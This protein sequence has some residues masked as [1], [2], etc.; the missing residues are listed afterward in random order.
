MLDTKKI[1][2]GNFCKVYHNGDWLMDVK[3]ADLS[4][5]IDKEEVPRAGTRAKGY[6][7]TGFGGEGTMTS[8]MTSHRFID[9]ITQITDDVSSPYFTE[10]L[11]EVN[12]PEA[13]EAKT[14][15]S[16]TDVQFDNAP[17]LSFE[18]GSLTEREYQFTFSGY[19]RK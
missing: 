3:A 14:F 1:V 11:F 9:L 4:L 8:Y 15:I 6:K 17:I 19:S 16:I 18:V 7:T 12:D 10:L 2:N 13:I 5:N